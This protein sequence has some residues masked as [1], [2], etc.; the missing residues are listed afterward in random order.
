MWKCKNCGGEIKN[1][2]IEKK[3]FYVN[4]DVG[5]C[6][7]DDLEDSDSMKDY[8]ECEKCGAESFNNQAAMEKIAD[9]IDEE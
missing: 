8:L 4:K 9:W 6:N 3:V 2:Y 7:V 1:T 5:D